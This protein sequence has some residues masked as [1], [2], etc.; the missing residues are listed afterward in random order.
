MGRFLPV[1]AVIT[2]LP[3]FQ[4]LR[5][6]Q[7]APFQRGDVNLDGIV[8]IDDPRTILEYLF[9]GRTSI[10]CDDAADVNDDGRVNVTT[11]SVDP[12]ANDS[13]PEAGPPLPP[14][15]RTGHGLPP[16]GS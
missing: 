12:F 6:D 14:G 1:I 10:D 11:S 8:D 4:G 5:G 9:L 15:G 13:P 3:A 7:F 2:A 16:R